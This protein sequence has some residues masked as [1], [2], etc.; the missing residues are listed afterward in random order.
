M[1]NHVLLIDDD[2]ALCTL[3]QGALRHADIAA[4]ACQSGAAG[5][6]AARKGCYQ[7]IVLDILMPGMDGFETLEKLR[8]GCRVPVLMLTGRDDNSSKVEGLR[9]GADDY[10]TK[11][12]RLEEFM[13]RVQ[14]LL[15][16]YLSLN[17][18][19]RKTVLE[20]DGLKIFPVDE[21]VLLR[22]QEIPLA[23]KEFELLLYC[24][25]NPGKI[26]SKKK[27]FEAVWRQDYLYDD[28]TVMATMSRLRKKLD[29][30]AGGGPCIETIKGMGYRFK[31]NL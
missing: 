13:A 15:R 19:A 8:A 9:L 22:G 29:P 21:K 23:K 27:L 5:I 14:A 10:L 25:R 7:L 31:L 30:P 6:A 3:L 26:L 24:A 17:D 18:P 12:F 1:Q 16:R 11:P 4:D 2:R 28:N 20:F